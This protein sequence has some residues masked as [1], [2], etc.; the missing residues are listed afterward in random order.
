ML[1]FWLAAVLRVPLRSPQHCP[2]ITAISK[3]LQLYLTLT[4]GI[5]LSP[6]MFPHAPSSVDIE[7]HSSSLAKELIHTF[8]YLTGSS[9]R[10]LKLGNLDKSV[11]PE[12]VRALF[13]GVEDTILRITFDQ[14]HST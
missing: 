14:D 1:A 9:G 12:Q 10:I 2:R 3:G 11:A 6:Y 5:T 13:T 7:C 8:R 4:L